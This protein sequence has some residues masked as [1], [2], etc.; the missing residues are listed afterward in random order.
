MSSGDAVA[1]TSTAPLDAAGGAPSAA[2]AGANDG[3]TV[4]T[5]SRGTEELEPMPTLSSLLLSTA[6]S[7]ARRSTPSSSSSAKPSTS[8]QPA[9]PAFTLATSPQ[10]LLSHPA[11]P[12]YLSSLLSQPLSALQALP[13]S[14][15]T[16]STSLD[17]DLSSLAFTRYSSFLLSYSAAQSIST[18]FTTLSDSLSALLDSTSS[19]ESA[20]TSFGSRIH[21]VR[22]KR[23]RMMRVRERIEEVEELLEAPSV[24]DA[25]VRAGYWSEAIDVAVRLEELHKRL[26]I[27]ASNLDG[28]EG[29]GALKLLDRVREEVGSALLSLRAGVLD[30]LLQ[31]SLKLPGAVR[32]ISILRR[33]AERGSSGTAQASG[34]AKELDEDSLRIVFLVAR[35]RCLRTELEGVEAQMAACGI[36]L[37]GDEPPLAQQ[38]AN[39]SI[40]ENDE[41]TRWT[42]R[43]IEVWREVVGETVGMYA[44]VFLSSSALASSPNAHPSDPAIPSHALTPSAP[45]HIFLT[46]ALDS[47]TSLLAHAVAGLSST[48]SLS[49]L[50]TQLTYCSHSFARYGL[51]FREFVQ[52]RERI[53]LR[54]GRIVAAEWELAGRKWEKEF[55][56]AWENSGGMALTA[57]KARRSGRVPLVDWLVAPEG[58][59]SLLSIPLPEPPV[60]AAPSPSAAWH[61]QPSLSLALLPPVARFLNAHAAALNSLRLVPPVSLF[62][63]LRR[64]QAVELDRATQVLAAFTDAWLASLAATP[65]PKQT[66]F[67]DGLGDDLSADEKTLLRERDEEKRAVGAAIAWFSRAVIPW[68]EGAL[69]TGVYGELVASGRAGSTSREA[70]IREALRRCEQLVAR[71]DGREYRE[72]ERANGKEETTVSNG[73]ADDDATGPAELPV[74]DAPSASLKQPQAP[75]PVEDLALVNGHHDKLDFSVP[76]VDAP[77]SNGFDPASAADQ[78]DDADAPYI[79]DET[80]PPPPVPAIASELVDEKKVIEAGMEGAG[81]A[82]VEQA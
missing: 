40:E 56:D 36:Q 62:H 66:G 61:H 17:N 20:A 46:T 26:S 25:C 76:P 21:S 12:S 64:A 32:G 45:L 1:S 9:K 38:D 63:P 74:L 58:L 29:R 42:K 34:K 79:V 72:E 22:E 73:L 19:L 27:S 11:A 7:L 81:V 82:K 69:E 31:R 4:V 48:A 14:L 80:A 67:D 50:L 68:C 44:E 77:V 5:D 71:I 59:S 8:K 55:R 33:I 3:S 53:E 51:D 47:L 54:I 60:I 70:Q 78:M 65:L 24:V 2:R 52:L 16:L 15:A 6:E 75:E 41:R 35:W 13:A 30:S 39:V 18:S 57:A 23:D 10:S 28:G 37:A 49:S 43:W